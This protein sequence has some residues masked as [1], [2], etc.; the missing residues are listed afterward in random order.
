MQTERKLQNYVGIVAVD[1]NIIVLAGP[2][3]AGKS[4][5]APDFTALSMWTNS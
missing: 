5:A 1:A 4:T 2:N 3:G